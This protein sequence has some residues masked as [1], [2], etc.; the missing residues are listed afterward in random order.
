MI[1]LVVKGP[2]SSSRNGS[3]KKMLESGLEVSDSVGQGT[4]GKS[5]FYLNLLIVAYIPFKLDK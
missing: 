5:R 2:K 4:S 1:R 3:C